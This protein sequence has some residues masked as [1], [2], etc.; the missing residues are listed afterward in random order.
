M[1][2]RSEW[3]G[4]TAD[5]N[6]VAQVDRTDADRSW[7]DTR[8]FLLEQDDD[9]YTVNSPVL[10][11]LG[12]VNMGDPNTLVDFA[13][14]TVENFPAE[15]YALFL[16]DHGGAWTGIGWDITDGSDQLTM[17]ELDDAFTQITEGMG[18]TI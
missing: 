15:H 13:L 5:V 1:S 2:T 16:S 7:T 8:R 9:P 4:S 6:F 12:E 17:P 3:V 18:R 11:S 14:W 10:E